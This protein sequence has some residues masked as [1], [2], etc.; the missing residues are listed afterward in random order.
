MESGSDNWQEI[1]SRLTKEKEPIKFLFTT[2][3]RIA[4]SDDFAKILDDLYNS[5]SIQRFVIDEAHCISM[6]GHDF[7]TD[8]RKL[9][10][11][12]DKYPKVPIMALTATATPTVRDD[13]VDQ[14]RFTEPTW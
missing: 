11:L 4:L 7:R 10:A 13:I 3:E 12:R 9:H 14:L 1:V 8:Y 2:P 6:W 5:N